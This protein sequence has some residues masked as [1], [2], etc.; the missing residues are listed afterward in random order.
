MYLIEEVKVGKLTYF[1]KWL[2]AS[3]EIQLKEVRYITYCNEDNETKKWIM[4]NTDMEIV[5]DFYFYINEYRKITNENTQKI[6]I[7][8]L[9]LF[10]EF[11]ELFEINYCTIKK[12]DIDNFIFFLKGLNV[13]GVKYSIRLLTYRNKKTRDCY[14]A[15]VYDF[16]E[17]KGIVDIREKRQGR[18]DYNIVTDS[19]IIQYSKD[20][21]MY[22]TLKEYIKIL[23]VIN[24]EYS[25][26]EEIIVR[27]MRENGL[28]IGEVLGLTIED[29]KNNDI[30][31]GGRIIIRNRASDDSDQFAKT[32]ITIYD[33][34]QYKSKDYW[35]RG[36]GYTTVDIS[37]DLLKK[38]DKY[39]ELNH[40]K[41]SI[42]KRKNYIND[43]KAD[44]VDGINQMN[45]YIFLNYRGGRLRQVGWNIILRDIFNKCGIECDHQY[46]KNNLNHKFRH[47]FAIDNV[48]NNKVGIIELKELLRNKSITSVFCYFRLGDADKREFIDEIEAEVLNK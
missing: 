5:E 20:L 31:N 18:Q 40:E 4:Y 15:Y 1:K 19:M 25:L 13:S 43:A 27:L 28:R 35:T 14:L 23:K 41:M 47:L 29:I 12:N 3:K 22:I 37:L 6:M 21:P 2:D 11:C 45:F 26:R 48:L 24:K 38:I 36:I 34:Y 32:A 42:K 7:V 39:I 10:F 44:V 33:R 8:S 16:L 46:R 30:A 17:Y 9:K